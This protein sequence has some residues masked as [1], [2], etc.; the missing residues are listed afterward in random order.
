MVVLACLGMFISIANSVGLKQL[1]NAI[2]DIQK[3]IDE[4][5]EDK[6][7]ARL[8]LAVNS[9][10]LWNSKTRGIKEDV[11]NVVDDLLREAIRNRA[12]GIKQ[13]ILKLEGIKREKTN[14]YKDNVGDVII[15]K[16]D[17]EDY[18]GSGGL[19]GHYNQY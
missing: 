15:Q 2:E 6:S 19:F 17:D 8:R 12:S 14:G 4:T 1:K 16:T 7:V 11:A 10:R 3:D 5:V 13:E 18:E 9:R